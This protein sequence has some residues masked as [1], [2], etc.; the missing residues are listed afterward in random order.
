MGRAGCDPSLHAHGDSG[1]HGTRH[2]SALGAPLVFRTRAPSVAL[3]LRIMFSMLSLTELRTFPALPHTM[4]TMTYH[5]LVRACCTTVRLV[6]A[7][8]AVLIVG[9][10]RLTAGGH[11]YEVVLSDLHAFG[12]LVA[13]GGYM[14]VDDAAKDLELGDG[15]W[16][17]YWSVTRAL[18]VWQGKA[19]GFV[20][21][22]AVGAHRIFRR[23]I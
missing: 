4:W 23:V 2:S 13:P 9:C 12:P 17:G 16:A 1:E 15:Q 21:V 5:S 8:A 20:H 3:D 10:H 22:A 7:A 6:Q 18:Q 19:V 11:T 14:V